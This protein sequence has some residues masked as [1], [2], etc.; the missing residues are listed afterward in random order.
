VSGYCK[1]GSPPLIC[2]LTSLA[3]HPV[4]RVHPLCQVMEILT[5]L[6]P[7]KLRIWRLMRLAL[8]QRFADAQATVGR[9][10]FSFFF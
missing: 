2:T 9:M 10:S 4:E 5:I 6:F 3:T 8:V 1:L 7:F